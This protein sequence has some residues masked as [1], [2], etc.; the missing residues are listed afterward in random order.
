MLSKLPEERPTTYG[1][2]SRPPLNKIDDY[3]NW[4]FELPTKRKESQSSQNSLS[5]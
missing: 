2:F 4:H 1:I 3:A 5:K